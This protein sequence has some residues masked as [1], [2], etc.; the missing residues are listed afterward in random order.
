MA[1]VLSLVESAGSRADK[2]TPWI[3]ELRESA[4][5]IPHA[6]KASVARLAAIEAKLDAYERSYPLEIHQTAPVHHSN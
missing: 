5:P 6:P 4:P 2:W 1:N 3:G